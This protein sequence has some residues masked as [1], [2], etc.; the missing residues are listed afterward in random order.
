MICHPLIVYPERGQTRWNYNLGLTV[1]L[2]WF[3][4]RNNELIEL[5]VYCTDISYVKCVKY[6]VFQV[7]KKKKD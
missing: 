2:C 4:N 6:Y 5:T 1:H 3:L 7:Q